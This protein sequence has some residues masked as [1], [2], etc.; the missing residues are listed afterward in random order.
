LPEP[1]EKI[2][3]PLNGI[4]GI[5]REET[6]QGRF[7]FEFASVHMKENC[8]RHSLRHKISIVNFGFNRMAYR[9]APKKYKKWWQRLN[10]EKLEDRNKAGAL[11][12]GGSFNS[13]TYHSY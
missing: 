6:M 5:E 9:D 12:V 8:N 3:P 11:G 10:E 4:L 13:G 7:E 1:P 2:C